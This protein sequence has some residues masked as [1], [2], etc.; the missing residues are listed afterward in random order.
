M[1]VAI[2]AIR[3][4]HQDC[5]PHGQAL[6]LLSPSV[7][8]PQQLPHCLL[9]LPP[10]PSSSLV[11]V[12]AVSRPPLPPSPHLPNVFPL[13]HQLHCPVILLAASLHWWHCPVGSVVQSAASLRL[14]H[15]CVGRI[16]A[17]SHQPHCC[18]LLLAA[19]LCCLP[20]TLAALSCCLPIA[21]A[22]GVQCSD[23][24]YAPLLLHSSSLY[25]CR[26]TTTLA[27]SIAATIECNRHHQMPPSLPLSKTVFIFHHHR[28]PH[29][30]FF[31]VILLCWRWAPT[32]TTKS[33][34]I[35]TFQRD[36]YAS[37]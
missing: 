27:L 12:S 34:G 16:V 21:A 2:I 33:F 22:N 13:S 4:P 8:P 14:P 18:V 30:Q 26:L 29:H 11:A 24:N 9:P 35:S 10:L 36:C 37:F 23:H 17:S 20:V 32:H 31:H 3:C 1:H 6:G 15:R 19:L 28:L 5:P 7:A 25:P